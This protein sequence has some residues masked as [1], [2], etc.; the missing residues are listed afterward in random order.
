MFSL[1][2]SFLAALLLLCHTVW[3]AAL[4]IGVCDWSMH[5]GR[6]HHLLDQALPLG[7]RYLF[8]LFFFPFDLIIAWTITVLK[9]QSSKPQNSARLCLSREPENNFRFRLGAKWP[10]QTEIRHHSFILLHFNIHILETCKPYIFW[11]HSLPM[12]NNLDEMYT[13]QRLETI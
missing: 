12:N 5:S 9:C 1:C 7:P 4:S 13:K 8:V 3:P 2:R 11:A 10:A 6:S